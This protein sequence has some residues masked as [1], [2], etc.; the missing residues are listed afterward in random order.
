[1]SEYTADFTLVAE[2]VTDHA[3]LK[4]ILRGFFKDQ[5]REPR[6]SMSQ[7]DRDATTENEWQRFGNWE[8][9]FRY[10]REGHHR[11]ALQFNQYLVVQVDTD[12]SD[13]SGFDVPRYVGGERLNVPILVERV[14]ERIRRE[15]GEDDCRM[16]GERILF[17]VCVDSLECWLLPLW[18]D[19]EIHQGRTTGCLD[20]LN[21]ELARKDEASVDPANKRVLTY[22]YAARGYRK[23]K[24]LLE[25]GR[26]NPSL[27]IFL[28]SLEAR[29]ITL[30]ADG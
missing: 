18:A 29:S 28:N 12:C 30:A 2:G 9:V 17:A 16:Y 1:M 3:V 23:R 5:P 6:F 19:Q 13:R 21:R 25:L 7:P 10:L 8:N 4:T 20:A 11:D 14:V 15:I 22:E 27:G 26:K 24:E